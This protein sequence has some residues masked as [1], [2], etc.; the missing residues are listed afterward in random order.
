VERAQPIHHLGP[1]FLSGDGSNDGPVGSVVDLDTRLDALH[2]RWME[3]DW[4][5]MA[6]ITAGDHAVEG[7]VLYLALGRA[8]S[9]VRYEVGVEYSFWLWDSVGDAALLP[10][11]NGK[12]GEFGLATGNGEFTWMSVASVVPVDVARQAAREFLTSGERPR[13]LTWQES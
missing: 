2:R 11:G 13:C 9:T 4:P 8:W 6:A 7:R 5:L 12:D 1:L 3:A 10:A